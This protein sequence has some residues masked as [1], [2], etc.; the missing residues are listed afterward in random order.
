MGKNIILRFRDLTVSDTIQEHRDKIKEAGSVWWGWWDR[1]IEKIS[2]IFYSLQDKIKANGYIWIFL[3]NSGTYRLYKA[4]LLKIDIDENEEPKECEDIAM[5]PEYYFTKECKAWFRFE[6][7]ID[8]NPEEL[9]DWV[10]DDPDDFIYGG[11]SKNVQGL[12]VSSI[13][14]MLSRYQTIY[15]ITPYDEKNH[16]ESLVSEEQ[17]NLSADASVD[18]IMWLVEEINKLCDYA[19][20]TIISPIAMPRYLKEMEQGL[21]RKIV[22]DITFRD[23]SSNIYKLLVDGHN[24]VRKEDRAI[25]QKSEFLNFADSF[26]N[27]INLFRCDLHHSNRKPNDKKKVGAFYKELCGTSII[28]DANKMSS[29]H[30]KILKQTVDLLTEE[31]N[32]V[33]K[34]I[35]SL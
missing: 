16:I 19:P 1:P 25:I 8:A 2:N 11:S 31:R 10:Y 28:D 26:I 21:K 18:E 6:S 15:F 27:N 30:I 4:K 32:L 34:K 7:I 17:K 22:D 20:Q 14:E 13:K 12:K 23:F 9:N 35:D 5:V 33:K 24:Q 3:A 29:C